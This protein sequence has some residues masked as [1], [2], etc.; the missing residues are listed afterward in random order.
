M[1]GLHT[2]CTVRIAEGMAVRT[3]S[4]E[5]ESARRAALDLLLA[6]HPLECLTCA[7]NQR[8]E[9][10]QVAAYMGVNEI[11]YPPTREQQPL[12][13]SN[14]FFTRNPNKCIL[15]GRCVRTCH[16]LQGV[17]A[18]GFVQ[19]G[20]A[21][22]IGTVN[23]LPLSETN[24]EACGE[25]V[26]RCPTGALAPSCYLPPT[27]KVKTIC[28]FCGTGCSLYLGVRDNQIVSVDGDPD[29]PVNRGRLCVKG[30][31]GF[32]FVHSPKRLTTP[33]IKRDGIFVEATWDEA[34]DLIATRFAQ[35]TGDAFAAI[36]SSRGSNEENY[37]VQKF[38]R[39][40]M[41]TNNVDNCARLCHAPS[42]TG[43]NKSFG[44]SGGTNPVMDIAGAACLFVIGSNTTEAHPVAGI[45]VRDAARTAK[46]IVADPREIELVKYADLWLPLRPGTD[47]PLLMGMARVIVKEGL[48]NLAFIDERCENV[49]E[50]MASLAQFDL[51]TVEAITGV[52]KEK[53]VQAARMYAENAPALIMYSLGITEHSHG[54][55][56]VTAL[57]NLALLTGNVGKPSAGVMPMRGQ[58]N[59]QGACDMGCIPGAYQGYQ[60]VT[61]PEIQEK[62]EKAWGVPLRNDAGLCMTEFLDPEI[63]KQVKALYVVGMDIAFSVTD[64][65]RVQ[66]ALRNM[67]FVVM[68]DLFLTDT[69]QF[70]DVVLPAASFA[71]K[72]G[73]FTNLERRV[74][75]IR[76][77][78]A[79]VG[80]A[81]PDWWITCEIAKRMGAQGFDY[82]DAGEILDEIAALTP[83]FAGLSFAKLDAE[84]G[85]QWPCTAPDHAGTPRLHVT[86]FNTPSGKGHLT[87][88][89]YR[90]PAE[91]ADDD[92]PFILITGRSLYHFHLAMTTKVPGLMTIEPEETVRM[93][94]EDAAR[95]EIA[96][97]EYVQVTSR[98]G[99]L[100]VKA[101]VTGMMQPGM[102]FMTFH[103]YETPTNVLTISAL[104]PYAKT[105]EFKVTA[106]SIEK[107]PS[108][109]PLA[110]EGK[111]EG[112]LAV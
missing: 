17:G 38:T 25:C 48:H 101:K 28:T 74:Q 30:R 85:I 57:G 84:G 33:L 91:H 90:P 29:S 44:T 71:E 53:I 31:Y 22:I 103:F 110:D 42:L 105:P 87:E 112:A 36:S 88:L 109:R 35:Y 59:V 23:D 63:G 32:D 58:N 106:I 72:D 8:C 4:P 56:N 15:C 43:L 75:R 100:R 3:Q 94:P 70:A 21:S 64:I 107:I 108:S 61:K 39:A 76:Q 27:Q 69:A 9:L 66:E 99:T 49:E 51:D 50:F 89:S 12:D 45:Q 10:Q 97:G 26:T 60:S 34:L 102:A 40:V 95:L 80:D 14:P 54:T 5:I 55:D 24:C 96:D 92:Y 104:D 47:V 16:D 81:K 2:A 77:A 111:K 82:A 78:I 67:E 65:T 41:G 46:L 83:Y 68:Q 73:T 62:F 6:D 98:R 19:R 93:N 7:R 86:K 37:I 11:R 13:T 52:A 1:R 18:V 20:T 79:P